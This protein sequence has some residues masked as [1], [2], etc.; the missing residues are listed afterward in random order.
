M[1]GIK[2]SQIFNKLHFEFLC[3]D[4]KFTNAEKYEIYIHNMQI[5]SKYL[6]WNVD[7]L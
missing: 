4:T 5:Y 2:E 6:K 1:F 3:A 7:T